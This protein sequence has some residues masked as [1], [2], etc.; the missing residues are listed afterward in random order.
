VLPSGWLPSA[1]WPA[2]VLATPFDSPGKRGQAPYPF[3]PVSLMLRHRFDSLALAPRIGVPMLCIVAER[4]LC[5]AEHA[6]RLF[7]AWQG[8]KR[9]VIDRECRPQR[10]V[11]ER[12]FWRETGN[13]LSRIS[14]VR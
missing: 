1:P 10:R 4:T 3:A 2:W 5:P 13:F 7:A 11:R 14:G 6:R 9:L 8:D 12:G